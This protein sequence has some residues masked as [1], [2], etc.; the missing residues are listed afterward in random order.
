MKYFFRVLL[1]ILVA[2]GVITG[3]YF[4]T[5]NAQKNPTPYL[6][7]ATKPAATEKNANKK[8]IA[9]IEDEKIYLYTSDDAIILDFKGKVYE[10]TDWNK[11]I[12]LEPPEMHYGNFDGDEAKEL[13]IKGVDYIADDKTTIYSLYYLDPIVDD[14]KDDFVVILFNRDSWSKL[15]DSGMKTEISQLIS[16]KKTGQFVMDYAD[17]NISYDKATGLTVNEH[18]GFF[19][20]LRN[21]NGEYLTI[22]KWS[23]GNGIY[24][25][26]DDNKITCEVPIIVSYKSSNDTQVCGTLSF[27]LQ[28]G[29]QNKKYISAKSLLFKASDDYK[30]SDPRTADNTAWSYREQNS[31]RSSPKKKTIDWINY[32]PKFDKSITTQTVD[33][34]AGGSDMNAIS[35][36]SITQG[37]MEL[38]AK[39]GFSFSDS[40][41]KG[42]FS[43][44]I[45]SG[46][47]NEYEISLDAKVSKSKA[48]NE[49]LTI[50]FDKAY[51]ISE[52]D[53]IQ[54]NYG[55]R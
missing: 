24:S 44:I 28:I 45:N 4:I 30:I 14:G 17:Q 38:T 23:R 32:T 16:S 22:D 26:T 40:Y 13:V 33:F 43:V 12:T 54:I 9:S 2:G 25:V 20:V 11:N 35:S 47:N 1:V 49:V 15:I 27:G 8:L 52:I 51:P 36:L 50:S 41:K 10:Y 34:S 46:T 3:A 42:D 53:S 39:T 31:N 19:K 48:G 18:V 55:T 21:A 37:G 6:T 29:L 5:H 7:T